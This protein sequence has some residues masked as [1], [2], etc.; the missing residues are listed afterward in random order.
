MVVHL[1]GAT[2]SPS[3]CSY[4]L[5][6]TA[7]DNQESFGEKTIENV[8]KNFYV[9][10]FL[11]CLPAK[12]EAVKLV[13]ELPALLARGGFRLSK[14]VSNE[15]SVM[16]RVP[17][18]EQA[19]TVDLELARVP[20]ERALGVEWNVEDDSLGFGVS[21]LKR[22]PEEVSCHLLLQHVYDLLG[23]AAL[24]VFPAKCILQDLCRLGHGW[25]EELPDQVL[26]PWQAWKSS[27]QVLTSVKLPSCYKL[28]EFSATK[29]IELH[30]F[31]DASLCGY[32]TVS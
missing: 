15:R 5:K 11:N 3:C 10:D 26:R 16:H 9:D 18:S 20:A 22:I 17:L 24:M 19:S 30:H 28:A 14:W 1:F 7:E 8:R 21:R 2:S 32:G 23:L 31:A 25:D 13:D 29:S 27:F 4:A 12:E 6:K